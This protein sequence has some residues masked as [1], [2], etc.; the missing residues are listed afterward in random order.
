M[1]IQ[2]AKA[3]INEE[4]VDIENIREWTEQYSRMQ[5]AESFLIVEK[6]THPVMKRIIKLADKLGGHDQEEGYE[7]AYHSARNKAQK[8]M[9]TATLKAELKIKALEQELREL[10][11][12]NYEVRRGDFSC[13]RIGLIHEIKDKI[14]KEV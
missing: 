6:Y 13:L 14:K 5:E 12:F 7:K 1:N 3:I 4:R 2:E 11:S 10:A 8:I 9:N